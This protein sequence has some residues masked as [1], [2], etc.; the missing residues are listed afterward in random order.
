MA[1]EF[2]L[3]DHIEGPISQIDGSHVAEFILGF[4]AEQDTIVVMS[5]LL[6]PTDRSDTLE[7]CFGIRLKRDVGVVRHVSEPDY[8]VEGSLEYVPRE[9]KD[10][11]LMRIG[12]AITLLVSS[13]MP[14]NITM[15]TY[16]AN[17]PPRALT[18]YDSVEAS[19][20]TCGYLVADAFRNPDDGINYWLFTRKG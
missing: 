5:I 13:V 10:E 12:T 18:K 17:L 8:S 9:Y 6:V 1:Y 2:D 16:Y 4:D 14:E 11:V 7:L 3:Q 19:I 20:M 15:E